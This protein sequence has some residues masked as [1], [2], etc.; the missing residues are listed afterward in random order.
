M[1]VKEAFG[2]KPLRSDLPHEK[3]IQQNS[4]VKYCWERCKYGES[5]SLYNPNGNLYTIRKIN[6]NASCPT[7]NTF[8]IDLMHYDKCRCLHQSEVLRLQTFPEDYQINN[9]TKDGYYIAG[10][11]VP[12]L[13]M[14]AIAEQIK[15]QWF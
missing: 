12:P 13:M 9:Q 3:E 15:E 10:M 2:I 14:R 7:I 8:K 4:I 5:L 6:P 1:T 11:S